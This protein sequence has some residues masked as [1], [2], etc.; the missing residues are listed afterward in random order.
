LAA[1]RGW[2]DGWKDGNFKGIGREVNRR[3]NYE[4]A[5]RHGATIRG[6]AMDKARGQLGLDTRYDESIRNIDNEIQAQNDAIEIARERLTT[7]R[8]EERTNGNQNYT[9]L[10]DEIEKRARDRL[11]RQDSTYEATFEYDVTEEVDEEYEDY[12]EREIHT[13]VIGV[14]GKEIVRTERVPVTRTRRVP[15][16]RTVT[17]HANLNA[18]ETFINEHANEMSAEEVTRLRQRWYAERDRLQRIYIDDAVSGRGQAGNDRI[19]QNSIQNIREESTLN[20][21]LLDAQGHATH[22]AEL[23]GIRSDASGV[24]ERIDN[25]NN[26]VL[27][28]ADNGTN[29]LNRVTAQANEDVRELEN[30][31]RQLE[32]EKQSLE[33]VRLRYEA[34]VSKQKTTDSNRNGS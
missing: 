23:L 34:S 16:T 5:R 17:Q 33:N 30:N 15:R 12:E 24:W 18:F 7:E 4:E 8:V 26:I 21:T 31:K 27:G 9:R 11:A 3:R 32:H 10:R 19:I 29:A 2:K 28:D 13:G 22:Q 1:I 6:I 25:V 20:R 14:N